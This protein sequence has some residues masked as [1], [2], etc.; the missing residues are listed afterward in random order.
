MQST[1]PSGRR[2][3]ASYRSVPMKDAAPRCGQSRRC[4]LSVTPRTI[5]VTTNS[6]ALEK[7]EVSRTGADSRPRPVRDVL[8]PFPL[9][10]V[11]RERAVCGSSP[12]YSL[13]VKKSRSLA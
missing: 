2:P 11:R 1:K 9:R 7:P 8:P 3:Q 5:E 12:R 10:G 13:A 4:Q 6:Q